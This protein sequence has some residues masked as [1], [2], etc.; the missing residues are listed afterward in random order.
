MEIK[1]LKAP[2]TKTYRTI[3]KG[4]VFIHN[5]QKFSFV[6]W[7][8]RMKSYV[9]KAENG[10]TYS[11]RV[12]GFAF[13]LEFEVIG[14][15]K[16][17]KIKNDYENLEPGDLFLIQPK[18]TGAAEI[19]KFVTYGQTGKVKAT[20]PLNQGRWTLPKEFIYTKLTNLK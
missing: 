7:K 3:E 9:A 14:R 12:S 4:D 13:K 16:L 17:P 19:Y 20:N 11:I 15:E 6:R 2:V 18:E 10:S 5:G 1:D 8:Q